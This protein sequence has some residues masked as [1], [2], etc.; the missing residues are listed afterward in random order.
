MAN[1]KFRDRTI[2]STIAKDADLKSNASLDLSRDAATRADLTSL[3]QSTSTADRLYADAQITAS[4]SK[5][6]TFPYDVALGIEPGVK[7]VSVIGFNPSVS[8]QEEEVFHGS[9]PYIYPTAPVKLTVIG[10]N[11]ADSSLGTG[12]R[13]VRLYG[14]DGNY[15]E[16]QE[17][18]QLAGLAPVVTTQSFFRLQEVVVLS[19]GSTG[20]NIGTINV[21][22]AAAVNGTGGNVI[23]TVLPGSGRT[24]LGLYTVPAGKT[25]LYLQGFFVG[26]KNETIGKLYIRPYGGVFM[27]RL[28]AYIQNIQFNMKL[29]IPF[30][31]PE[32]SDIRITAQ[33]TTGTAQIT[34]GAFLL[35]CDNT[36]G[37]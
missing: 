37:R 17:D 34:A 32:K 7:Y 31:V 2:G 8:T 1:I 16:I 5:H 13:L 25:A 19:A 10:T 24:Q 26:D 6:D 12:A 21:K 35:L 9:V 33:T 3:I 20:E 30:A 4:A 14:L 28:Q 11:A 15:I 29:T 27:V 23:G 18:I 22:H 36:W